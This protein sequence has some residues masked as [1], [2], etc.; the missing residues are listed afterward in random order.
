MAEPAPRHLN[1][2]RIFSEYFRQSFG[3]PGATLEKVTDPSLGYDYL[4]RFFV[5]ATGALAVTVRLVDVEQ[6]FC[7]SQAGGAVTYANLRDKNP[8]LVEVSLDQVEHPN[9]SVRQIIR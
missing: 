8:Q 4:A 7:T 1:T 9:R 5:R 3:W 6:V 2:F